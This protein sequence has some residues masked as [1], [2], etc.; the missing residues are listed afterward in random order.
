MI[1]TMVPLV[2]AAF[3]VLSTRKDSAGVAVEPTPKGK[4][5]KSRLLKGGSA[6]RAGRRLHQS[7]DGE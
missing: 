7:R 6:S 1:F 3:Y 2:G 5:E 4:G